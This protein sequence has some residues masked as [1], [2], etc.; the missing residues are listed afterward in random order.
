MNHPL[1]I[2][3]GVFKELQHI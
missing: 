1:H 2:F 3:I